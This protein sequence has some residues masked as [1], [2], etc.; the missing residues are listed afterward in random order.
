MDPVATSTFPL[1]PHIQSV[2]VTEVP[3]LLK[4]DKHPLEA[5]GGVGYTRSQ[6]VVT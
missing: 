2:E 3:P 1:F 4:I 5:T 6:G